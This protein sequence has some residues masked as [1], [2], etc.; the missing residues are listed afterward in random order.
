MVLSNGKRT[1]NILEA[2]WL[3]RLSDFSAFEMGVR[4]SWH[5]NEER[6]SCP[7]WD[8]EAS[9]SKGQEGCHANSVCQYR[10]PYKET[11]YVQL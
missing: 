3:E 4:V 11:V 6:Q 7:P 5:S 2:R 10:T 9:C 8:E 1:L